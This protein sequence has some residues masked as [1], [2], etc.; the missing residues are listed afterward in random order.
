MRKLTPFIST[1]LVI[2]STAG[3]VIA[4]PELKRAPHFQLTITSKLDLELTDAKVKVQTET[5]G[6]VRYYWVSRGRDRELYLESIEH[7][8]TMN[9]Q[10]LRY[11]LITGEKYVFLD[12]G[13]KRE[14]PLE[15]AAEPVKTRIIDGF[16]YPLCRLTLDKD[17]KEVDRVVSSRPGA[18]YHVDAGQVARGTLFHP[19]F[20]K[21]ESEWTAVATWPIGTGGLAEGKLTYKKKG[22]VE[23]DL[24]TVEVAGA[25]VS[26][27]F[28]DPVEPFTSKDVRYVVRGEQTFDM[29]RREWV[30]GK[31]TVDV[32]FKLI[33]TRSPSGSAKGEMVLTFEKLPAR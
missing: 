33:S 26:A 23:K 22:A 25:L 30:S 29:A 7:T 19:P 4:D 28:K 6:H 32:S 2:A 21:D 20:P 12:C 31:W 24:Q 18:K 9:G 27:E 5:S 13:R 16:Y 17:G 14:I 8:G 1:V 10:Q 11:E 3:L 15:T